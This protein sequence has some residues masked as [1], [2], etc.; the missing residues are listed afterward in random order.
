MELYKAVVHRRGGDP[1]IGPKLPALLRDGGLHTIHVAVV[2]PTFLSGEGKTI[3][4]LTMENIAGAVI[5][6]GFASREDIDG[7]SA[8][9]ALLAEN[10][11]TL[12][13]LPRIFQVWGSRPA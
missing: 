7:I 9:L 5:A 13:S 8:E 4:Q 11:D 1:D 2:Q 12:V 10:V 6:E 3:H